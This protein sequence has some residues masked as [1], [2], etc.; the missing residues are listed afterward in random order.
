MS[1]DKDKLEQLNAMRAMVAALVQSFKSLQKLAD[2]VQRAENAAK[3][4]EP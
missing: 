3:V 4:V 1:D 2:S